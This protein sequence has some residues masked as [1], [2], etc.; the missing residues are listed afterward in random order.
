[1]VIRDSIRTFVASS[2]H[3]SLAGPAVMRAILITLLMAGF[4][5]SGCKDSS[6]SPPPTTNQASGNPL[7]APVDYLGAVAQGHKKSVSTLDQ[8]QINQAIQTFYATEG[9]YPKNLNELVGPEYLPR[10][11]APP[12]GMKYDY[13][14]ATGQFK[15]V[16][17]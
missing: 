16:P 6:K 1:M 2:I 15:I 9:R 11:P 12:V 4:F 14:A 3:R 7:T 17:Q 8:V 5:I 13:N 10:L